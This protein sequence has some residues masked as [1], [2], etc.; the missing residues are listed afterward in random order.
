MHAVIIPISVYFFLHDPRQPRDHDKGLTAVNHSDST[1]PSLHN[2]LIS[3]PF[4]NRFTSGFHQN[5]LLFK[6]YKVSYKR[7]CGPISKFS[8]ST[9]KIGEGA[10][11]HFWGGRLGTH[12]TQTRL[13]WGLPPYQVASWCIQPFEIQQKWAENWGEGSAPFLARGAGSQS[14]TM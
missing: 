10:P 13:G 1:F 3:S 7:K 12:L 6:G 14:S 9:L 11:P 8:T 2:V 4:L 5:Y